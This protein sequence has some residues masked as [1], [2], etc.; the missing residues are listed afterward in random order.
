MLVAHLID[1]KGCRRHTRVMDEATGMKE[2][3]EDRMRLL[4]QVP[5]F[6]D[7]DFAQAERLPIEAR[8]IEDQDEEVEDEWRKFSQDQL[9]HMT[10]NEWR[11]CYKTIGDI[12]TGGDDSDE[13]DGM[14]VDRYL[15]MGKGDMMFSNSRRR[16]EKA[17]GEVSLDIVSRTLAC[18][19]A[20]YIV[21]S[22]RPVRSLIVNLFIHVPES[23]SI[24]FHRS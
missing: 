13:E 17:R 3:M 7:P 8:V 22:R 23:V 24:E 9:G 15:E 2:F 20:L 4:R 21:R 19:V 5:A 12:F 11:E 6:E 14:R 10:M 1:F 16:R 18:P